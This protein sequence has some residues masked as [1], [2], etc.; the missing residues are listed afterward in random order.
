LATSLI[1]ELEIVREKHNEVS[2]KMITDSILPGSKLS[3]GLEHCKGYTDFI[4]TLSRYHR[5]LD[6]SGVEDTSLAGEDI[7]LPFL[8]ALL[9]LGDELDA[10]WDCRRVNM[11]ILKMR[12]IPVQSKFHWW[13]H[14]YVQ[15][16]S[17]KS[18]QITLYFRFP[19]KYRGKGIIEVFWNKALDSVRGQF[20]EVYNIL[21]EYGLRLHPDVI[22]EKN[23]SSEGVVELIPDDLS[24]Y[25]K[26]K[27]LKTTE[28]SQK[29]SAETGA[30]WF[31]DGV[32]Y[33]DNTEVVGCLT[34]VINLVAEGRNFDAAREIKRCRILTMAPKEKMIF[35]G[36]AG[37]CCYIIGK[38]SEAKE[39][40]ED[41]LKISERRDVQEIYKED[42]TSTRAATLG[43]IGLIYS[44]KGDLDNALK[45]H[46]DALAIHKEIGYGQGKASDLGNI[47]V[48][49]KTKG[50]LNKALEYHQESL[51]I[52]RKLG[53]GQGEANQLSNIGLIY[54]AKG[55]L[56]N[57]LK[58][59]EDALAIHRK[60]GY[61]QG[62][63]NQLGNIGLIYIVKG[64]LNKALEY[65]Q[66]SLKIHR[67]IGYR[68]GE[69]ADLGN[70]GVIYK[71]KGNLDNALKY[72]QEALK[73]HREI[74]RQGE[75]NQLGNI[76]LIYKD[77]GELDKALKYLNDARDIDVEVGYRQGE[78]NQLGN[79]GLIYKAKGELDKALKYLN[80]ALK[81]HREIEYRQG[82]AN[83][84]GNIAIIYKDK[85]D[86][87]KAL[88]YVKDALKIHREIGY[89]QGE[90]NDLGNIGLIYKAK[91]DLNNALRYNQEALDIFD[92]AAPRFI[93]QTLNNLATI[94]FK[95]ESHEK[96]F[97]Y[98]ARA[99]SSSSSIEQ[100][101]TVI[102]PFLQT[103]REMIIHNEWE[104]L[105]K[106][107]STY[108]SGIITDEIWLNFFK[109]IHEYAIYRKTGDD[110]HKKSYKSAQQKLNPAFN[111]LLDELLEAER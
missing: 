100:L 87:N 103:V 12:D 51:K 28:S 88:K 4:V 71:A 99:I 13:S 66:E 11:E 1:E 53:Y 63:A 23:Y 35:S 45:Y 38:L 102:F 36:L 5:K 16:I 79:I 70:I 3:L 25:I 69:A 52:H 43:N 76:G 44:A 37:N 86:L 59:H 8:I 85:G 61:I 73:I 110:S 72:Y 17:I 55:D 24:E 62:E 106:I 91:G 22:G 42:A 78:A 26:E 30:T 33:S 57:A 47:G 58:Y 15:S 32:A 98:L 95:K 31:V 40:Y 39:Y 111:K 105:R 19:K 75:A 29:L 46:E 77:K 64:D 49:Y 92:I 34:S 56:D 21:Y 54:S 90:A 89:R 9:R 6:I 27:I 101:N 48:I 109:A 2:A 67:G 104:N 80:D 96:G 41:A 81:I 83:Q 68:Y 107:H 50:D 65:H 7:R 97:E 60:L 84:L 82:E 10:D 94:Y 18:G 74:D 20:S 14:H 93:V 108:T